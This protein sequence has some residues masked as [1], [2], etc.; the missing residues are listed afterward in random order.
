MKSSLRP[1]LSL[2]LFCLLAGAEASAQAAGGKA[3]V[4]DGYVLDRDRKPIEF[5]SVRVV[6]TDQGTY[7]DL[8]GFYTLSLKTTADSVVLEFSSIGYQTKSQTVRFS[9]PKPVRLNVELGESST[10]IGTVTVVGRSDKSVS[11]EQIKAEHLQVDAGPG[12]GVESVLGTYAGV[13]QSN[14]LSSQYTVRGGNYDENLVYV[15]GHEV[16]RA[17]LV[18]SAQQEGLSFVNPDLVQSI[19][20]SAGAFGAEYGDRISSVLDIKY[21]TPQVP[22]E[23]SATLGIQNNSLYLGWQ[24]GKWSQ[25]AGVRLKQPGLLLKTLET[26]G[27]YSPLYADAQTYLTYKP[28]PQLSVGLLG[29]VS[30]TRYLHRPTQRETTFG[31]LE[32]SQKF[33]I[34]FDGSELDRFLNYT[35]A[36]DLTYRPT[37]NQSHTLRLSHFMSSESETYDISGS[38][39]LMQEGGSPTLPDQEPNPDEPD[40]GSDT[41]D[42]LATGINHDHA[43]NRLYYSVSEVGYNGSLTPQDKGTLMWGANVRWEQVQ[44]RISEWALLDSAGYNL[45]RDPQAISVQYNLYAR[46]QLSSVRADAYALYKTTFLTSA[47]DLRFQGGARL[48]WW[49]FNRQW[50][51]T[52]RAQLSFVPTRNDKFLFRFA[53]GLYHQAP[54]YKEIRI[55]TPDEQGNNVVHLSRSVKAQSSAQVLLGGEYNF[56]VGDRPFKATLEGYFKYLYNINPYYINNIKLRYLGKNMG[57]GYIAGVDMKIFGEFVPGVDSWLTL[58]L[59]HSRQNIEG[60]GSMPMPNAPLYNFSLFFQDYF[61]GY[62]KIRLSLR[63]VLS[64]GLPQVNATEGFSAPIFTSPAYKR[65]DL[66][67]HYRLFDREDKKQAHTALARYLK[68]ID[69]GVGI[70]NLFD[71]ANVSSYFWISD[72]YRNRYAVPDYLTGRSIDLS[73]SAAF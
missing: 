36:A 43:R 11:M 32:N 40:N 41:K 70:F 61:P 3:R 45:P 23:G 10:E 33:T 18:R 13:T 46:E 38:Y 57:T 6:G 39:Y 14:E 66:G 68:S 12:K 27:E 63:A 59:M 47:G 60:Y 4:I 52:A 37:A 72:A 67:M 22:F 50:L 65:V 2:L 34:Y 21:K 20:F 51:P 28:A 55:I 64:G 19:Y 58:S 48:A 31:T 53:T 7:S 56:L 24:R 5:A 16:R 54:F 8:K 49:S 1:L 15:N 42:A 30:Y 35:L 17:L 9:S 26:K 69:L 29:N 71:M 73:L 62:K 44:D 25:V